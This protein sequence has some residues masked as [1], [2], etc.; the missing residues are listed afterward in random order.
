MVYGMFWIVSNIVHVDIGYVV[1][2]SH[3]ASRNVISLNAMVRY[4]GKP[5]GAGIS[6]NFYYSLD[7]GNW[8]Y[9]TTQPT[10]R[11]GIARAKFTVTLPGEYDFRATVSVS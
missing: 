1:S 8:I 11:A 6:V 3:S 7:S 9:F 4:N 5:A 2:L 10:N